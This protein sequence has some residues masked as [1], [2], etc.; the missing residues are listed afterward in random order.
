MR[1]LRQAA[2][3]QKVRRKLKDKREQAEAGSDTPVSVKAGTR[4]GQPPAG[5]QT[6]GR[7]GL[8]QKTTL[9]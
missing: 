5:R 4:T 8:S 1:K 6:D 3:R 2:Q 7:R 9:H